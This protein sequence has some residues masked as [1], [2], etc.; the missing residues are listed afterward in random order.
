M[1]GSALPRGGGGA[2]SNS[3]IFISYRRQE[4]S[5]LAAWLHDW[6]SSRFGTGRVFLDIDSIKPGVDFIKA[7]ELGI[8]QSAALVVIIGPQWLAVD[9]YGRRRVDDSA[10]PVRLEIETALF[11]N[12]HIIPVLLDGAVMPTATDLPVSVRTITRL[13]AVSIRRES[14]RRDVENLG[15]TM[16]QLLGDAGEIDLYAE[17]ASPGALAQD[18]L[19]TKP[20][21][22]TYALDS[23][24]ERDQRSRLLE[25]LYAFYAEYARQVLDDDGS[26]RLSLNMDLLPAKTV[27]TGDQ[28]LPSPQK[29]SERLPKGTS[30]LQ[31]FDRF[32]GLAGDGIL[33]LGDP[34][35]GKTTM[36]FELAAQLT[37]CARDS[38]DSPVPVYVPLSSW[39]LRDVPFTE[40]LVEQ[41]NQL[42]QI[43]PRL[44]RRWI[45]GGQLLFLLDG[46]DE[47]PDWNQ[48]QACVD[49][50]N[51]FNRFGRQVWLP[52]IVA[53]RLT[54]YDT[55]SRALQLETAILIRPLDPQTIL[56][57]L[58]RAGPS[59]RGV[60][61][62]IGDEPALLDLLRSPLLINMLNLTYAD[63]GDDAKPLTAGSLAG[64]RH[65]LVS[66]YCERR[67][68]LER[69][70]SSGINRFP[71]ELTRSWLTSLAAYMTERQQAVF[72]LDRVHP[73]WLPSR[74]A[75]Q[76]IAL[77]PSLAW[78]ILCGATFG[79]ALDLAGK[80]GVYDT[81]Y[82]LHPSIILSIIG[83]IVGL[84]I[85]LVG[86]LGA[87]G[88]TTAWASMGIIL[89][90]LMTIVEK[91]T[92]YYEVGLNGIQYAL[93]L[94]L[95]GEPTI[96]LIG[97][98]RPLAEHLSWS[99]ARSR[100][101][102]P[103]RLLFGTAIGLPLALTDSLLSGGE[104]S[105][106]ELIQGVLVGLVS[107]L[108]LGMFFGLSIGFGSGL[109]I[110]SIPT[111]I[112]PN[113]GVRNSAR[114]GL[115]VGIAAALIIGFVFFAGGLIVGLH[116]GLIRGLAWGPGAG[117]LWG[118][119]TG[120]GAVLQYLVLRLLLWRYRLAPLRYGHWLDYM[121]RL[122]LLY[123]GAGGGYLFIHQI[124]QDHFAGTVA[125]TAS[126]R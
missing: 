67:L 52:T 30:L 60:L 103:L 3:C 15:A 10:D 109:R 36:V 34:G 40:W 87:I 13:N 4:A 106:G 119:A 86:E 96:H 76:V 19:L 53:S 54:E 100:S 93:L 26:I 102:L 126:R 70:R 68:E 22:D 117:L 111:R 88:R 71:P 118:L 51:R 58:R 18:W 7:I 9:H 55:L 25:Q 39:K 83:S 125:A 75:R 6:L 66:N 74:R 24:R 49:E 105:G 11:R 120:L 97:G 2:C 124:V 114:Y 42:Y 27:R 73:N 62:A 122:R 16:Y 99:W 48:R 89:G 92:T 90:L 85:G 113:Q 50:I 57:Y 110:S 116:N 29:K 47:I 84:V 28:L 21:L 95:V 14:A 46:L 1:I 63:L 38:I 104:L 81:T 12:I 33:V 77:A 44:S 112:F 121:V 115:V 31:I 45:E 43:P 65:Q 61:A 82:P 8:R 5:Y 17:T 123:R 108:V 64:R 94:A 79:L 80:L 69:Q 98:Y 56:K 20:P 91:P 101:A 37:S 107:G 23:D 72:L 41:L 35:S 78:A 59:A 32:R